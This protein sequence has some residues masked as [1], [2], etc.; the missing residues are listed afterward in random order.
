MA[1]QRRACASCG[2]A[3]EEDARFCEGCGGALVRVCATCGVEASATAR[4]CRACGAPLEGHAAQE[5]TAAVGPSRKTVTVLFADLAGSTT[6]EEQ[7]DAETAREVMGRY[8]ELLRSTADRNRAGVTKYIGDGFMA[9][10]GVPE[11]GPDDADHG[12]EAAVELQ[13][14]FVDFTASVSASHGIDLALRVAV[15]TGEVVVD[16]GDADLVGDALNVAARL[17]A[18]CPRGQVVVGEE[19]WRSTRGK[20][21]YDS[22]GH[23]QVK[24]RAAPVPV[25]QWLGRQSEAPDSAPFVGRVDEIGRLQASLDDAISAHAVRLVTIIG[26][27]GVGKSRLVTEFVAMLRDGRAVEARCAVEGTVALS[28]IVEVLRARDLEADIPADAPERE[29]ILRDLTGLTAGVP[30]SVEE[31]FWALRRFVE[32]LASDTP[33]IFVVDD[34]HWADTLLLDFVEHLVEWVRDAP[35][36]VLAVARPELREVRPDLITVGRLVSEA[37]HVGGLDAGATAELAAGVLGSGL[38]SDLAN[39]LP[40]STGGN[41]LFVRELIGMLVHDG[42]LVAQPEGWR[43]TIDVDAIAIPP[44]IQALLA[45]R[46]ERLNSADRRVLEIASVVGTD[47]SLGAVCALDGRS[48]AEVKRSL[49]RLRRLEL[50]QPSGAYVGD[51]PVWR[52]HHVLIRDVA[53]RRL[54]KSDRADLHKRLADWVETGGASA[55]FDSDEMIARHLEAAHGYRRELGM[56]DDDTD[57]LAFRSA[58]CYLASGRRALDRDELISAGTQAARGAALAVG[59]GTLQAELLLVGCEAFLSAGDVAAGAPLVDDLE[60]IAGEALAPWATCY[61]CQFVV[62]TEPTRLLEVHDR[63]QSAID[64]FGRRQ[65]PAGLAKAHRVRA[66]ARARLGRIGDCEVDLFEAL[67]AARQG[68]D[69]RQITAAL[70]AAPSAAL[71]GPS[72]VPKAGG[73]CLDVVRMQR[74]TTAAPSLEAT[75][76]RC[77]AL[78]E[79]LRGR[80]DKARSMLADARKVVA[81]LGLRHGLMETELFAGIIESMEGDAVAAEPHFRTALDGLGVLGAGADAGQAAALLARSVLAQGRIDEADSYATESERLAGHNL[82]AAIAWRAV[83][84]DISS[85]RGRHDEA[86]AMA[87][88]AVAVAAGTDLVL[89]HAEACLTLAAV[90]AAAGD[91]PGAAA[92]RRDGANLYA[93]KETAITIGR[94]VETS[95]PAVTMPVAAT[96]AV[97]SQLA[98]ANRASESVEAGWRAIENHDVGS[99]LATYADQFTYDDRRK[100]RGDPIQDKATLQAAIERIM[101]RYPRVE[102]HTSAV[103]GERLSLMSSNWFDDAGNETAYL[104]LFEIDDDGR[105]GYDG[106]FDGDDFGAAYRELENRYYA[107]EGATYALNGNAL[108]AFLDAMDRLDTA[109]A[110]QVSAPEFRWLAPP[111]TLTLQDRSVDGVM[112]WAQERA[113]QVSSVKNYCSVLRWLSPTCVIGRGN[114]RA[115]GRDGETY[116]WSPRIY[117]DEFRDGLVVSVRQFDDEQTAFDYVDTQVARTN[118]PLA[119]CNRASQAMDRVESAMHG[120]DVDATIEVYAEQF[121]YDDRRRLSG[122]PID[123]PVQLHKA[124][125]RILTQFTHFD[126][127]TLAVRGERLALFGSHWSDESGNETSHFHVIE[128]DDHDRIAYE[129]RFSGDDFENA[130]L[131]LERR[132]Y[133]GEGAA[134]AEIGA[135]LIAMITAANRGDL[136]VFGQW[137]APGLQLESRSRSI[138]PDRSIA[139]VRN[140][141]EELGAMVESVRTWYPAICWLSPNWFV[142]REDRVAVG[143]GREKYEWNRVYAWEIRDGLVE[144]ICRFDVEDEEAAFAYVDERM[145]AVTSRLKSTNRASD[146]AEI[147]RKAFQAGDIDAVMAIYADP[148]TYDDRRRLRGHPITDRPG[149]RAASERICQ[150]FS[151]FEVRTLAVRGERLHLSSGRW[152]DGAGNESSHLQLMEFGD[153][154]RA[155]YMGRFDQEDFEAAY[156]E[157]ERRYY[158]GEGAAF[159]EAVGSLTEMMIAMSGGDL[160]R[161][162]AELITPDFRIEA[163]SSSAFPNRSAAELRDTLK[164]LSELVASV[165]SWI[166]A[167]CWLSPTVFVARMERDATGPDGERYEWTHLLTGEV[168]DARLASLCDFQN[169][170]EDAAFAYA[171][172]RV[173]A[174]SSRLPVSNR[175]AEVGEAVGYA[176][177]AGDIDAAVAAYSDQVKYDDRRRL[178][179]DPI[180]GLSGLW[181]ACARISRQYS[182]F[183]LRS[184]AVRGERLQLGWI[185]W[186][187]DAGNQTAQLRLAE[188]GDDD[189]IAYN[190]VFDED[191]FEG[192]YT[193]LERR[194]YAGEGAAFAESGTAVTDM[195]IA[196]NRGDFDRLFSE[197]VH[198]DLKI[199]NRS[200]TAFLGQSATEFRADEEEFHSMVGSSRAR[201]S[202]VCWLSPTWYVARFEREAVGHDGERYDWSRIDVMEVRDGRLVSVCGFDSEHEQQAFAYA[203]ERMRAASSRLPVTNRATDVGEALLAAAQ[204]HD[205]DVA[206]SLYSDQFTYE[207]RRRFSGGQLDGRA[208]LRAAIERIGQQYKAFEGRTFAVR[209]ERLQLAWTRW[210]DE[211]GNQTA[212]LRLIELG[213]DGLIT[214][215]AV[216]DEDDFEAAYFELERRYYAGE[217]AGYA[218]SGMATSEMAIALNRADYGKLFDELIHPDLEIENRAL[219]AFLGDS[220]SDYR[221]SIE[222]LDSM[223]ASARSW[224]S[225]VCWLSPTWFVARHERQ[226]VGSD[227]ERYD[228]SLIGVFEIRDGRLAS[229][230]A[231]D[232]DY[233]QQAFAYAEER[234]RAVSTRLPVTNRASEVVGVTAAA[235]QSGDVDAAVEPYSEQLRFEDRRRLS[236]EPITNLADL[237]S[238]ADRICAQ[239]NIIEETTLAVRGERLQLSVSRWSGDAENETSQWHVMELGDDGRI[240]LQAIFDE[241]DFEAAYLELERRYYAGEGARSAESGLALAEVFTG[242]NRNEHDRVF[243]ELVTPDFH[244]ENLSRNAFPN[245]SATETRDSLKELS[246]MVASVRSWGSAICWLSPTAFVIRMERDAVGSDGEQYV[247]SRLV[248][249][250]FHGA[251]LASLGDFDVDDEGRAFAFAE[252]LASS[253]SDKPVEK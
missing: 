161:M 68:G 8:H 151:V 47:F 134:Y 99:V 148:M 165:R 188:L 40:S 221:A 33:L 6:F 167:I 70:G 227:G 123:D 251:R 15:N 193:E 95:T 239:Y 17:E 230:C 218:E 58:R 242:M 82:K 154:G 224:N 129:G 137:T 46:L 98:V 240:I 45:S 175:A 31:T 246:G 91:S 25:Y 97:I 212:Q 159:A 164:E 89:D 220:A 57:V 1:E 146:L 198:P 236:G 75:S 11:M 250:E 42:V 183:E 27:P 79:L 14:R 217:G 247:W 115:I 199:E 16:A 201:H 203:E 149:L 241:D 140:S 49:D 158:A 142:T 182:I 114:V 243:S 126:V 103:R 26:D 225:T 122:D 24:G 138:W 54:L 233:E 22:L 50:A 197:F 37:V 63:L 131:E 69:H 205:Y 185:R 186:S 231:F 206:L 5:D 252:Q 128:V 84:A 178:S 100:L 87:R 200:L 173:R 30:G 90:L 4:F 44:T 163:R 2:T 59:D 189:L 195:A 88:D 110:H 171:E 157:L 116:E 215:Q 7:V 62:Y 160:D 12:V 253:R 86:T 73:R 155:T 61:R 124:A 222:Q 181:A 237:R 152:S 107:G 139:E 35:V 78:L 248:A 202:A 65:D 219:T 204:R 223:I 172:E 80:A 216:F 162:F 67:I 21:R 187:D 132:Y 120:G 113:Q 169:D 18:E 32:S 141:L 9:V 64:E 208:G 56:H 60:R 179:G 39:R 144:T 51:E 74:M 249:G 43:L 55:A 207:D 85:A 194:Y 150:Q 104:H 81:D 23:V 71:W 210:S 41:P 83:R 133:A 176:I 184:L 19:T 180:T 48:A 190:A 76:L 121:M 209:G 102:W 214:Y 108:V 143:P 170:D 232:H 53:Y 229:V 228:W 135:T 234:V 66:G 145:Q 153:D 94:A 125:E 101:G 96:D 38:P 118:S 174:A 10:W 20:N 28:P 245:R 192:A 77:L 109:A 147:G 111:S 127:G 29:R 93:A 238:T 13:A 105:I 112:R 244:I 156:A 166:S 52:F 211:A 72:P 177:A 117:V 3:N 196:L 106:R 130:Y 136:D 213:D 119:V 191:D 168:R 36:L 92:A 226:A 235:L 34:I